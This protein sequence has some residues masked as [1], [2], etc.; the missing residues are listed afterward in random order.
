MCAPLGE[1]S[2]DDVVEAQYPRAVREMLRLADYRGGSLFVDSPSRE[3]NKVLQF[4]SASV[5]LSDD[6]ENRAALRHLHWKALKATQRGARKRLP[7][8]ANHSEWAHVAVLRSAW[9]RTSPQLGIAYGE[10]NFRGELAIGRERIFTGDWPF[11]IIEDGQRSTPVEDWEAICWVSDEDVDY[12]ELEIGLDEGLKLQRQLCLARKDRF[13][14]VAD[15]VLGPCARPLFHSL[16]LPLGSEVEAVL[17]EESREVLLRAPRTKALVFP[18]SLPEWRVDRRLGELATRPGHLELQQKATGASLYAPLWIDLDPDRGRKPF[19]W[20]QLS[21]AE[22]RRIVPR[23]VA[24]GYRVQ[25]GKKQWLIYRSLTPPRNRT[26]LGHNLA[27]DF[28]IARF[29]RDGSVTPLIE[30]E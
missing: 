18:L 22:E 12:L 11:T 16:R 25:F 27:T 6:K 7:S 4:F 15:A 5:K 1:P 14:F 10:R 30:V 9:E 26:V 3:Q 17:N 20:R 8:A 28:L 23:E 13:L 19:T 29:G 21:V 2:C 24:V